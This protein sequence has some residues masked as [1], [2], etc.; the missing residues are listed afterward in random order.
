MTHA[1]SGS[2]KR[3]ASKWLHNSCRMEVSKVE[4][5]PKR[6]HNPCLIIGVKSRKAWMALWIVLVGDVLAQK[7]ARL[8]FTPWQHCCSPLAS[9][10]GGRSPTPNRPPLQW[11]PQDPILSGG[12]KTRTL[13]PLCF[14]AALN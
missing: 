7:N 10:G 9:G 12:G 2:S 3:V 13:A 1:I 14:L 6:L 5:N 11:E 4:G 8:A